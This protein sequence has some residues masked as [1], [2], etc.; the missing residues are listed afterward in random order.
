[1]EVSFPKYSSVTLVPYML[2]TILWQKEFQEKI[3]V[4]NYVWDTTGLN[5]YFIARLRRAFIIYIG[6]LDCLEEN[7]VY[8]IHGPNWPWVTFYRTCINNLVWE[9]LFWGKSAGFGARGFLISSSISSNLFLWA[10]FFWKAQ[11][12]HLENIITKIMVSSQSI[13]CANPHGFRCM[14]LHFFVSTKVL[15]LGTGIF[16]LWH[17]SPRF[18]AHDSAQCKCLSRESVRFVFMYNAACTVSVDS[19]FLVS[20]SLSG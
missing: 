5:R 8:C 3:L 19:W 13:G 10:M 9:T 17:S 12:P 16:W 1:M 4:A 20:F 18:R 15:F 2:I 11:F 7:V 6:I 14:D